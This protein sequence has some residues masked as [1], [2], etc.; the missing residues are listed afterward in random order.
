[1]FLRL[2]LGLFLGR[3]IGVFGF[4][5]AAVRLGM[6]RL[7]DDVNGIHLFGVALL[8]GI[9]LAMSLFIAGLACER[10]PASALEVGRLGILIASLVSAAAGCLLLART[11]PRRT[12]P[13]DPAPARDRPTPAWV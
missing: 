4:S 6:A 11:P 5:W 1:M 2:F 3:Q 13:P 12:A 10:D 9:G 8:W 7:P